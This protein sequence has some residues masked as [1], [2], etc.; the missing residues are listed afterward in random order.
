MK[1]IEFFEYLRTHKWRRDALK[2]QAE[3]NGDGAFYFYLGSIFGDLDINGWESET[4][5]DKV[6]EICDT[7]F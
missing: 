6:C 7:E 1:Q 5:I 3:N 4:F 2:M